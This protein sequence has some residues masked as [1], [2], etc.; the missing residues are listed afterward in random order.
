MIGL[1]ITVGEVGYRCFIMDDELEKWCKASVFRKDKTKGMFSASPYTD[2][3]KE[4]EAL[5]SAFRA[6]AGAAA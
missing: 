5:G 3:E 4:L 6:V 1:V 2:K